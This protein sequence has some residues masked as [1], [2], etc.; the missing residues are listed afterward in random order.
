MYAGRILL[1]TYVPQAQQWCWRRDW[2]I[3]WE[4]AWTLLWKFS[5]LNQLTARELT[6]LVISRTCGKRSAILSKPQVDLRD[7]TVFDFAVLATILRVDQSV[8][9]DAFLYNIA[10]GTVL[11][12]SE[13]LRWCDA[14]MAS[15]FHTPLF[16][17]CTTHVCPLHRHTL[18]DR[19]THCNQ[20]IPYRGAA[21]M[22]P[23]MGH[24]PKSYKAPNFPGL[25]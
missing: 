5:Y 4:S 6:T 17:I 25:F 16:Q 23:V 18:R 12:S 3:K 10:P 1:D 14:C 8:V 11:R 19:C 24:N 7:G 2:H 15:G 21:G 13:F 22:K 9:R 20:K